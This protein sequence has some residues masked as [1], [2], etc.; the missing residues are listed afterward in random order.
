M[1]SFSTPREKKNNLKTRVFLHY[2]VLRLSKLFC[3][4]MEERKTRFYCMERVKWCQSGQFDVSQSVSRPIQR[5][6]DRQLRRRDRCT[7]GWHRSQS[8]SSLRLMARA[9]SPINKQINR[10]L[11]CQPLAKFLQSIKERFRHKMV[12]WRLQPTTEWAKT[13]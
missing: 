8:P 4:A 6:D 9:L 11:F 2:Y 7:V 3:L 12:N 1:T 13:E 10:Y 5:F